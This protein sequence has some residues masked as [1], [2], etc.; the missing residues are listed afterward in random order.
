MFWLAAS[1]QR[2]TLR[3]ERVFLAAGNDTSEF[4]PRLSCCVGLAEG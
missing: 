1:L 3:V 2:P 4:L